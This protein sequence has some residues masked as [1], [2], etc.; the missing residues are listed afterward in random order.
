MAGAPGA[1]RSVGWKSRPS[2]DT[3]T[4][5]K[6]PSWK[7]SVAVSASGKVSSI[8]LDRLERDARG[9]RQV[10]GRRR[11][12]AGAADV[13]G[14]GRDL[15][16][17]EGLAGGAVDADPVGRRTPR[18][19]T[20]RRG[21]RTMRVGV[22]RVVLDVEAAELAGAIEVAGDDAFDANGCPG[23]GVDAPVPWTPAISWVASTSQPDGGGG[24]TQS[25]PQFRGFGAPAVK[26]ALLLSVSVAPPAARIA[27][28]VLVRV[29]V[30]AVSESLAEPRS[31]R[32]RARRRRHR[33]RSRMTARRSR[34]RARPFQ[35]CRT[36]R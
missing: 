19:S 10:V 36:S 34:R 24:G 13:D 14:G 21:P 18:R 31:R 27:A 23:S 32:S 11:D 15:G 4:S 9:A 16:L 2:D 8:A 1:T 7:C 28:V 6:R 3:V 26:S 22:G 12:R 29:G 33:S 30:G 5:P 35:R 17:A 25:A 20:R